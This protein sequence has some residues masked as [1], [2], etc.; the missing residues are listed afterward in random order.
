MLEL[1]HTVNSVCAQNVRVQPAEKSLG[2]KSHL[3]SLQGDQF[4]EAYQAQ[5]EWGCAHPDPRRHADYR[6]LGHPLLS[7][8]V[9]PQSEV[10]AN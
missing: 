10:D 8:R 5:S 1:Y 9:I 3:M 4:G 6:V 7:R 2:W